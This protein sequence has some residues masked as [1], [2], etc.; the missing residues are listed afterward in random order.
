VAKN[1]DFSWP[2]AGTS[3]GQKRG[4][5]HGHGHTEQAN[6]LAIHEERLDEVLRRLESAPE[7][8]LALPKVVKL[9]ASAHRNCDDLS[10]N[11][12]VT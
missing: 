7:P 2:P 5:S 12:K 4:L 8:W 9:R 3:A 10:A 1:G 6:V 11:D